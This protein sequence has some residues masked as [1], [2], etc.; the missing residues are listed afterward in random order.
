MV[1]NKCRVIF[2]EE[3]SE[4]TKYGK[5]IAKGVRKNGLFVMKIGNTPQ[6]KIC[7]A[8]IDDNSTL[9]HRRLGHA[10]MRLI[11]SLASKE[12]VRNLPK[13]KFDKHFCNACKV[14]KKSSC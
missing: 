10:N 6:D 2:S 8:S 13:L 11:Q 12:L 3:G 1:D 14:G 9:W 7:L 5:T 4:I